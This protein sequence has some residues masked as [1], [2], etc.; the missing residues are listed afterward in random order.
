MND[1]DLRSVVLSFQKKYG[2]SITFIAKNCGVSREHLSRWL[3]NN[4]YIISEEL[5][6]KIKRM[7]KGEIVNANLIIDH[8]VVHRS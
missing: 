7:I 6:T 8:L 5:K 2:T 3:H 1:T 4:S